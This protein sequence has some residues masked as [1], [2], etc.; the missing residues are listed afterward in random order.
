[1]IP[2][3]PSE[4]DVA[5]LDQADIILLAGG[6]VETGWR[7]F[8]ETGLKERIAK[9]YFEGATLIGVSVGAVQ[10][11]WCGW[12]EDVPTSP[13]SIIDTFKLVPFVISTHDEDREWE[14]LIM[15]L[16][17]LEGRVHGI[18]IPTGSGIIF[19]SDRS[20][21]P[22]RYAPHEFTYRDNKIIHNILLP[23][24]S[25]EFIESNGE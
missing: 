6:D 9:R 25:W 15:A 19:H 23:D 18:G 8:E 17:L 10:L 24:I 14:P 22:F 16:R 20:I 11:G 5:Y 2:S 1:M 21:Q 13:E 4:E 12:S 3:S 7:V